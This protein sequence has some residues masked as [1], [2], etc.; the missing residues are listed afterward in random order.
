M[1]AGTEEAGA[2][3]ASCLKPLGWFPEHMLCIA[4]NGDASDAK[5]GRAAHTEVSNALITL[6]RKGF[7]SF[8]RDLVWLIH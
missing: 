1:S 2:S 6:K 4:L 3:D 8:T 7:L 5:L